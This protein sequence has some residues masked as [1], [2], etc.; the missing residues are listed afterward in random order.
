M[1]SRGQEVW[2]SRK[3]GL[4]GREQ[5]EKSGRRYRV[6]EEGNGVGVMGT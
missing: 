3:L 5:G 2:I 4:G 1:V 6:E